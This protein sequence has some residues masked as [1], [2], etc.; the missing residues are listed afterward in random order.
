MW[1]R[2]APKGLE[3]V[4]AATH[5]LLHNDNFVLH[6]ASSA[7]GMSWSYSAGFDGMGDLVSRGSLHVNKDS[8]SSLVDPSLLL[9]RMKEIASKTTNG[10]E[11]A[12]FAALLMA[13]ETPGDHF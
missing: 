13:W 12:F 9:A 8:I 4:R 6:F 10:D 2:A 11:A 1:S 7:A 5:E 3:E